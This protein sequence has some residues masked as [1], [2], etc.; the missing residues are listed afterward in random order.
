[1][2]LSKFKQIRYFFYHINKF[3]IWRDNNNE[4]TIYIFYQI[5]WSDFQEDLVATFELETFLSTNQT[6]TRERENRYWFHRI[7]HAPTRMYI[8]GEGAILEQRNRREVHNARSL[9]AIRSFE[10]CMQF[11][12]QVGEA[13]SNVEIYAKTRQPIFQ[14]ELVFSKIGEKCHAHIQR[15][16]LF[17]CQNINLVRI[18]SYDFVRLN[19]VML[20]NCNLAQTLDKFAYWFQNITF[21]SLELVEIDNYVQFEFNNLKELNILSDRLNEVA[22][23]C[24]LNFLSKHNSSLEYIT[25]RKHLYPL[26]TSEELDNAF[27]RGICLNLRG[28]VKILDFEI[29]IVNAD[30]IFESFDC[31]L[32]S[33][34]VT[35][36]RTK[37][38]ITWKK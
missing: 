14:S 33:L 25:I 16:S 17:N 8:H 35:H 1:M 5:E 11:S 7:H 26:A 22:K 32:K 3:V 10:W 37:N 9:I 23:V 38:I 36:G 29:D 34:E 30:D 31:K 13:L 21:L 18:P 12:E 28:S 20:K 4:V 24:L 2:H 15:I 27:I 6:L 19:H